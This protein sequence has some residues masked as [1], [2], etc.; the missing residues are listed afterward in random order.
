MIEYLEEFDIDTFGLKTLLN[1]LGNRIDVM[2]ERID[3]NVNSRHFFLKKQKLDEREERRKKKTNRDVL[4][5]SSVK[6]LH[7]R[8]CF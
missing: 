3:D 7:N 1:V 2:I 4:S 5:F 6:G 8:C